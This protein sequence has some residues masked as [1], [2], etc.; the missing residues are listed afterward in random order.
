MCSD[1]AVLNWSSRP[2]EALKNRHIVGKTLLQVLFW[3]VKL[4]QQPR[5]FVTSIFALGRTTDF[6]LPQWSRMSVVRGERFEAKSLFVY[7][8]HPIIIRLWS[9][10]CYEPYLVSRSKVRS[11]NIVS[12][13]SVQPSSMMWQCP[14]EFQRSRS[15]KAYQF[16]MA[17]WCPTTTTVL[18]LSKSNGGHLS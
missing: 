1:W 11:K 14:M 18:V 13:P 10:W 17:L 8:F 5:S 7:A 2:K 3:G 6:L 15:K 4:H 12:I 16:D 9:G